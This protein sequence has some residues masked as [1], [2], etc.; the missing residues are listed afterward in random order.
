MKNSLAG[1]TNGWALQLA[2]IPLN[3]LLSETNSFQLDRPNSSPLQLARFQLDSCSELKE[4][5]LSD[6]NAC[7]QLEVI[8]PR[9]P[10]QLASVS[11]PSPEELNPHPPSAKISLTTA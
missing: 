4:N 5:E 8:S 7:S 11:L 10:C 1:R 3:R 2:P 6:P 9:P